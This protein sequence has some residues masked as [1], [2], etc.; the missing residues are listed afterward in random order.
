MSE[1]LRWHVRPRLR[2]PLLVLSFE[3][4]NDAGES[5]TTAA[6]Y[7]AEQIGA[8]PLADIEPELFFDFTVRR[9]TLEVED[10]VVTHFEWPLSRFHYAA[11][12]E[13]HE[14]VVGTAIEPHLRWQLYADQIL[15]LVE[16]LEVKRCVMLGAY[17]ADVLY[18]RPVAITAVA[19]DAALL[20][21]HGLEGSRYEGPTGVVGMLGY[22]LKQRGVDF[23]ALWAGLP[24]YI[25]VTP[26]PRG[27]LALLERAEPILDLK[28]DLD[29]AA[30]LRKGM[31]AADV[32]DGFRRPRTR[33]VRAR[34]EAPRIRPVAP[35]LAAQLLELHRL[36]DQHHRN[37]IIDR[38]QDLPVLPNQRLDQLGLHRLAAARAQRPR[39]DL[40]VDGAPVPPPVASR[41]VC[42]VSGQTRISTR[43]GATWGMAGPSLWIAPLELRRLGCWVRCAS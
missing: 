28:L 11:V 37:P 39:S 1:L 12:D 10:G 7:L 36:L 26:N 43:S 13:A 9:P 25:H 4:W 2:D 3:G 15:A 34:T 17:L 8:A 23:L 31:R 33:R 24:H 32:P 20:D 40:L 19:S 42:F 14:L 21:R 41:T 27:A 16:T 38:I 6:R 30:D 29:A 5:A 18:S 22:L 35:S